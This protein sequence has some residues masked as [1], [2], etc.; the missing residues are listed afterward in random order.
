M[1]GL[2]ASYSMLSQMSAAEKIGVIVALDIRFLQF[3]RVKVS[4][5]FQAT[6]LLTIMMITMAP[7]NSSCVSKCPDV[8]LS[9]LHTAL[10]L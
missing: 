10:L 9:I 7:S 8:Q 6:T 3:N 5:G 4:N 2:Y 1:E